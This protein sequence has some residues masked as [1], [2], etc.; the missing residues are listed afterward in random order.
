[1][2]TVNA[3]SESLAAIIKDAVE[4]RIPDLSKHIADSLNIE[5][6]DVK[7]ALTEF[8]WMNTTKVSKSKSKKP[9]EEETKED[10][11]PKGKTPKKEDVKPKEEEVKCSKGKPTE[12]EVK[13]K[14]PKGSKKK[15]EVS[16][17]DR[18][19]ALPED[20]FYNVDTKKQVKWSQ[21]MDKKYTFYDKHR[22]CGHKGGSEVMTEALRTLGAESTPKPTKSVKP[23][24]KKTAK[25]NKLPKLPKQLRKNKFGN[26]WDKE[27]KIV[28]LRET[29]NAIGKQDPDGDVVAF[30]D[31]DIE[32]LEKQGWKYEKMTNAQVTE[33]VID[34]VS[35]D[36]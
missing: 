34:D 2:N 32:F 12:K 33:S 21:Q 7:K 23:T 28:F 11:K 5:E 35:D 29:G 17:E 1:M 6:D 27:S 4:S 36:E 19:A 25:E 24:E 20:K 10:V 31:D 8:N 22:I 18:I 3:F 14:K 30:D 9:K 26:Y 16:L 13:G 15:D